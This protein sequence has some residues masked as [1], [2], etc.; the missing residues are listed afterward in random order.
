M[1]DIEDEDMEKMDAALA[2]VFR[3]LSKKKSGAMQ[4]KEKKDATAV[5]HFKIRAL[6]LVDV[7]LAHNPSAVHVLQIVSFL[8]ALTP[9]VLKD[10][11]QKPL[12]T[13]LMSTFT[14]LVNVKKPQTVDS[15][16]DPHAFAALLQTLVDLANSGSPL[17]AH[18]SKPQ[19][20]FSQSCTLILKL[21]Q[22]SESEEAKKEVQDI[23]LKSLD[24]FFHKRY[25]MENKTLKL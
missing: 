14:K 1:D 17:V 8:V 25:A 5:M 22:Q 18:L 11:N 19:P 20:I 16:I 4:K 12:E 7:Y 9:K 10:K 3:V 2:N 13:R 24:D 15:S 23:Y 6:D 21:A